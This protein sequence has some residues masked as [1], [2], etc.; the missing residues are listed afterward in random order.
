MKNYL[1][2]AMLAVPARLA[3]T[4]PHLIDPHRARICTVVAAVTAQLTDE[5][6]SEAPEEDRARLRMLHFGVR[7]ML[8][9]LYCAE[10]T[11]AANAF[12]ADE[13]QNLAD[14]IALMGDAMLAPPKSD[15]GPVE[16]YTEPEP[17]KPI[18]L[19]DAI[20]LIL[21]EHLLGLSKA[22]LLQSLPD[23][24]RIEEHVTKALATLKAADRIDWY[25]SSDDPPVEVYVLPVQR[26]AAP[27]M[28]S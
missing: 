27:G 7:Q 10:V 15:D 20:V 28:V 14:F 11:M 22:G 19:T 1:R 13:Q 2:A 23:H 18:A 17:D 12:T 3:V 21:G 5:L 24:P 25:Q 4:L 16:L 6:I 9:S 8:G 26:A